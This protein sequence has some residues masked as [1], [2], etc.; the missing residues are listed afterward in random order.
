MRVKGSSIRI[1]G[2]DDDMI[3]TRRT[4]DKTL[5]P[6]VT[7][8]Y[9]SADGEVP[10]HADCDHGSGK[11]IPGLACTGGRCPRGL[12]AISRGRGNQNCGAASIGNHPTLAQGVVNQRDASAELPDG[13]AIHSDVSSADVNAA[14]AG[15]ARRERPG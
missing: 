13:Q 9:R 11:H 6:I 4:A 8:R 15:T 14:A 1:V 12:T 3:A 2:Y 5:R 7:V 10:G